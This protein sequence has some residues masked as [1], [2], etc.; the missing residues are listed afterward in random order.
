MDRINAMS[1]LLAVVET[2]S[3]S[4]ASRALRLPLATVSRRVSELETYLGARLLVRSNRRV[5]LT[6]AGIAYVAAS[7]RILE[8]LAEAERAAGGEYATPKGA[9]TVTAPIVFGRLHVLP[10]ITDFLGAYP[11][12]S[13][14]LTLADG[15]LHL[16]EDHIDVALRIGNLP[17]SS[18]KALRLGEISRVVCASPTYLAARGTPRLPEDIA[19]H[20]SVAFSGLD[21]VRWDFVTDGRAH[22]VAVRP[23][24]LVN[25]A[26]A[27]IDAVT[28]GLGLTRVLSYQVAAAER[29]G[30]LV[31]VLEDHAPPPVPVHL[32]HSGQGTLPLKLRTFLDHAAPRLRQALAALPGGAGAARTA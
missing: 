19:A 27:A 3:L 32:V 11:D 22:M 25:T 15:L 30:T 28:A 21:A 18:M 20:D 6:D 10:V 13:V 4:A 7:R 16:T 14:R 29:A 26:E 31:R 8:E 12:I 2:G 23:R 9:L 5:S 1:V 17:D 24:L